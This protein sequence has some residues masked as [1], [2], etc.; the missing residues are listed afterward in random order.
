M[1][2]RDFRKR[3]ITILG[4]L[5]TLLAADAAMAAYSIRMASFTVSP[6][7]ELTSQTLQ[8]RLLRADIQRSREI[9]HAMPKSRSDCER[10]ENSLPPTGSGYSRI[11]AEL[12]EIGHDSGLQIATLSF[13][14]KDLAGRGLT[15]VSLDATVSG[16]YVSVVRFLNGLQR[17]RNHYVVDDL[18]LANDRG[19][20]EGVE[21]VKVN[22]HLRSYFKAAA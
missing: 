8:L 7:R 20:P 1:M 5:I 14:P 9:Q 19:G 22:L 13:H 4:V 16:D 18:T 21:G 10:F 6:Q 3:Q 11:S 15:E 2:I 12:E 17:S